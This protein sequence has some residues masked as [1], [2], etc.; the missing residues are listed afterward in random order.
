MAMFPLAA[1]LLGLLQIL[2]TDAKPCPMENMSV[3]DATLKTEKELRKYIFQ[4]EIFVVALS[5]SWCRYCCHI[6]P[7]LEAIHELIKPEGVKL[8]RIDVNKNEWI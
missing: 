7:A 1:L 5:A 8:V 3:G 4:N 2:H 6:E